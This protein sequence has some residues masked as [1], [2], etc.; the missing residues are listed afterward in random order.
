MNRQ[1]VNGKKLTTDAKPMQVFNALQT[2]N[3]IHW[4]KI[5]LI[6]RERCVHR[7]IHVVLTMV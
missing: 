2:R 6:R 1:D 3:L 5:A 4:P 7:A